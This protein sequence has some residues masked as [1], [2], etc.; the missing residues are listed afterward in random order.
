MD[1]SGTQAAA[2]V[3]LNVVGLNKSYGGLKAVDDVTFDV[4]RD[5]ILALVGDTAPASRLWSRR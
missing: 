4:H 5:E 1:E 3:V 2:P